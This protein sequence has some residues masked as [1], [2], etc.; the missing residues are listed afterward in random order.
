VEREDIVRFGM[1]SPPEVGG[2]PGD[3]E[4]RWAQWFLEQS[5]FRDF[6][7]AMHSCLYCGMAAGLIEGLR[8]GSG[9]A[10]QGSAVLTNVPGVWAARRRKGEYGRLWPWL[11]GNAR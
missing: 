6:V 2:Q 3:Y 7:Y 1:S 11:S 5:F 10:A 9:F 4:E 8:V